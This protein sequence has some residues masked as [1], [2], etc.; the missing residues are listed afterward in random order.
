MKIKLKNTSLAEKSRSVIRR[1]CSH[2][3][4]GIFSD[5]VACHVED[6]TFEIT[7]GDVVHPCVRYIEEGFE[8][9]KWWMV[10]TPFYGGN[11][12]IENPRLC[13]SD[14]P[15]GQAPTEWTYYCT[16]IECPKE[17]YN[18]DPTLFFKD[19]TLYVFWRECHTPRVHKSGNRFATFGCS[20]QN[21]TVTHLNNDGPLLAHSIIG[22]DR[23]ICPTILEKNGK[24]Y[25]YTIDIRFDPKI[26]LHF[27][28]KLKKTIYRLIEK[29]T[30]YGLYNRM[31]CRGVAVWE[32]ESVDAPFN[33]KKTVKFCKKS[34]RYNPWHMDLFTVKEDTG[35]H[36]YSIVQTTDKFADICLAK[37]DDGEN[38]HLY[39]HP[40]ITEKSIAGLYKPTVQ[41]VDGI[42]YLYYTAKDESDK[43]LHKLYL[44]SESWEELHK[45]L[46]KYGL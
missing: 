46:L 42:F 45:K 29:T 21:K 5:G 40:L 4:I 24:L 7:H 9:H 15:K 20:V 38:F 25:A 18:S 27:P 23:E 37:S 26:L 35:N 6:P 3:H 36:L 32:G 28:E 30:A 14:A 19:R 31:R 11:N 33:Y 12:K 43:S 34:W 39:R 17:G 16:I 41:V 2:P 1:L 8:G 22:E 10:Y 44:I 13:F